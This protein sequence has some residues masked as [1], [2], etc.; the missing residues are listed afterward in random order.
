MS[1]AAWNLCKRDE[2]AKK[3]GF[4]DVCWWEDDRVFNNRVENH[5]ETVSVPPDELWF[6]AIKGDYMGRVVGNIFIAENNSLPWS[7]RCRR[8]SVREKRRQ[9]RG[10]RW[11]PRTRGGCCWTWT[12]TMTRTV[13]KTWAPETRS[14]ARAT[15][16]SRSAC[17]R[18][19][20]AP[21][22]EK[23]RRSCSR[24][25]RAVV[26]SCRVAP[27]GFPPP[28]PRWSPRST[29]STNRRRTSW[30]SGP[31]AS[32][33]PPPAAPALLKTPPAPARR[34]R[35]RRRRKTRARERRVLLGDREDAFV[36]DGHYAAKVTSVYD[37]QWGADLQSGKMT[38][39]ARIKPD[40]ASSF[41]VTL[42]SGDFGWAIMLAQRHR[43]RM[44]R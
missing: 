2:A 42:M 43:R 21:S 30:T 18:T 44:L 6:V 28:A 27:R 37:N 33:P 23:A 32:R 22:R 24:R 15:K 31:G 26:E 36:F 5:L 4:P 17:C 13:T 14:K 29:G 38:L 20:D 3:A 8:E 35:R 25:A 34:R 16:P 41:G 39:E 7:G 19:S 10:G 9:S 12:S 40:A 1:A 11:P